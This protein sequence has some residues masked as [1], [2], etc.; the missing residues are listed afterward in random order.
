M[1]FHVYGSE[2]QYTD[3]LRAV[4]ND[5]GPYQGDCWYRGRAG[6]VSGFRLIPFAPAAFGQWAKE[7]PPGEDYWLVASYQD[8][9][10]L[11]QLGHRNLVLME[12]GCGQTYCGAP[13]DSYISAGRTRL[14]KALWMPNK[15]A[16]A[17]QQ[18][19]TETPVYQ[20]PPYRVNYLRELRKQKKPNAKPVVVVS[21]HYHGTGCPEQRATVQ[22]W[23]D[24]GT[25][26]HLAEMGEIQLMGHS[27]PRC[28]ADMKR[29]W[30][31]LGV[32]CID[33]FDDVVK[34]ADVYAIDNS[35]TL[36]EAA[37]CDIPVA[38]LNGLRYRPSVRHGLRFWNYADIGIQVWARNS[39]P[40]KA[41]EL[42]ILK[43]LQ[44]DPQRLRREQI[45][46]EL[47]SGGIPAQEIIQKMLGKNTKEMIVMGQEE[48]WA[49]SLR[50][51]T[52]RTEGEIRV[53]QLFRPGWFHVQRDGK[54]FPLNQVHHNPAARR[55][56][57][58]SSQFCLVADNLEVSPTPVPDVFTLP[59]ILRRPEP[60]SKPV[61]SGKP[62][63]EDSHG[64][65]IPDSNSNSVLD[66][67][68]ESETPPETE[69]GSI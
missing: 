9:S 22:D 2:P 45:V 35:S 5:L 43:T 64:P 60:D 65:Q 19:S 42:A 57:L 63:Q 30:E 53:N 50:G 7:N 34:I 33:R 8:L 12:H 67:G 38:L 41:V 3:H 36:F 56:L 17:L 13:D 16:A 47:F 31:S 62:D 54:A 24:N 10:T 6:L 69:L 32:P 15:R 21:F 20:L 39:D 59:T 58:V 51:E 14:C 52:L 48:I 66:D 44:E 68:G 1:K 4:W 25:L 29:T 49:R 46:Q 61:E 18:S 37:A 26:K 40:A 28:L 55:N 11:H 23:W 27:H